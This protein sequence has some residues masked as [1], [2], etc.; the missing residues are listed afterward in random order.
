MPA[1]D[2]NRKSETS[3]RE[4]VATA[5]IALAIPGT[6]FVP[7]LVGWWIDNRYGTSPLW[8]LILLFTGLLGAA[9]D[10]YMLLKRL[11]QFK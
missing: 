7:A 10:V 6:I 8:F 2:E 3:W 5:G 1:D 4:A 9:Y 11:G